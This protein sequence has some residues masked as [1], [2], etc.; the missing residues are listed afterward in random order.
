MKF[1]HAILCSTLLTKEQNGNLEKDV[2]VVDNPGKRSRSLN[3][4]T[5]R[6]KVASRSKKDIEQSFCSQKKT[7]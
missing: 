1:I 5:E 3:K 6:V 2:F 4:C 7:V